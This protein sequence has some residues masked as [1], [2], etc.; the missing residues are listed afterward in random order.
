MLPKLFLLAATALVSINAQ[1][2]SGFTFKETYPSS[3][4]KPAPKPEWMELIKNANIT[5]APVLKANGEDGK[6]GRKTVRL[7]VF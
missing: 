2:A 4:S 6:N 5:N 1:S 3:G 7:Y